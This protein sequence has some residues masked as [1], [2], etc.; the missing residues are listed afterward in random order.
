MIKKKEIIIL[1]TI[2]LLDFI[3]KIVAYNCLPFEQDVNIIGN[4]VVFYLTYNQDSTGSHAE[5]IFQNE[6]NKNVSII[7]NCIYMLILLAYIL[8]IKSKRIRILYKVLIGIILFILMALLIDVVKPL[9]ADWDI[10]HRLT[11]IFGKLAVLTVWATIF[12]Y[13][14]DR[15]IRYSIIFVI[16]CGIGNLISY[17]YP[18][19]W[20]IDFIYVDTLYQLYVFGIFNLADISNQ[21]GLIALVISL[22]IWLIRKTKQKTA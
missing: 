1:L 14:K 5:Y 10:S 7:L 9:F 4:E 22:L 20:V 8:Y 19:F 2:L 17:F 21:I 6:P 11:S 13:V 15:F 3:T 12:Y 16:A 18:P